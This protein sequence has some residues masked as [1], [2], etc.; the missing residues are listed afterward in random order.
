MT[1]SI[2]Y[3]A[4]PPMIDDGSLDPAA[5]SW[6]YRGVGCCGSIGQALGFLCLIGAAFKWR[7]SGPQ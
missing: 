7:E 6:A 1:I 4:I 2:A 5:I 3:S